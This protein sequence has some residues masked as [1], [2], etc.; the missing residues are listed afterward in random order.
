MPIKKAAKAAA[1]S[2]LR[3][4]SK[5]LLAQFVQSTAAAEARAGH[6]VTR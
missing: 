1:A 5:E 4:I 2:V 6:L 3:E